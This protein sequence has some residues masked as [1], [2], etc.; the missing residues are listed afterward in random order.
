[1]REIETALSTEGFSSHDFS[2]LVF[3]GIKSLKTRI[4]MG[5][6]EDEFYLYETI[7]ILI[8]KMTPRQFINVFP[9]DKDYDGIK[10]D[11]KDYFYTI[12][13]CNDHG[14]DNPITDAFDF[15][16][17]YWNRETSRFVINYMAVMSDIRKKETGKSILEEFATE[18]GIKTYTRKQINGETYFVENI[19]TNRKGE[20]I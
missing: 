14:L 5:S 20:I 6:L 19:A 17:D 1:M 13:K 10:Y 12:K 4:E 2:K 3:W 15:L 11:C 18:R 7:I 16:W 9:I 8:E